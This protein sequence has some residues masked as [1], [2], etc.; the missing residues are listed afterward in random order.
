MI[1]TPEDGAGKCKVS[2]F[3]ADR[4]APS[5]HAYLRPTSLQEAWQLLEA[6]PEA[7]FVAGGTDVMTGLKDGILR[8]PALI[9][10]RRVPDLEG[11]TH[12]DDA[13]RIGAMTTI[14]DLVDSEVV[15]THL[16]VLAEGARCLGS[17]QVRNVAT[18][19][20]NLCNASPCA[21]TAPPLLVLDAIVQIAGP[22]GR[23][24]IPLSTFFTGPGQTVLA[25][26]EILTAVSVPRPAPGS[27]GAFLN[28][29]RT[30]L[31]ITKTSVAVQAE[32]DGPTCQWARVAVGSAAPTP[33]RLAAVEAR[34]A[35]AR[36]DDA[37][38][39]EVAAL[40]ADAVAPI[41]DL[42][43]TEDYRRHLA[44][45]LVKRALRRLQAAPEGRAP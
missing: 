15:R 44:G 29:G 26:G 24:E 17:R 13:I 10:L 5:R 7:R 37:T 8:P 28:R 19:G 40:T 14:R 21:D 39:E 16:P 4:P 41:T 1:P 33:L 3:A 27:R 11:V 31:D 20:G 6:H 25:P 32:L 30:R 38:L 22:G 34:L 36:L 23:R 18:V 12:N 9:S 45:V 35:G 43:S 42:R 2:P